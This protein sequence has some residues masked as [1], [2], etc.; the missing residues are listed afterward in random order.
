M[1]ELPR[2]V[3][4]G[5]RS[6]G[7][8]SVISESSNSPPALGV[9]QKLQIEQGAATTGEAG[10]YGVPVLLALVAVGE[11][12]VDVLEGEGLLAQLLEADD[13][14]VLGRVDPGLLLDDLGAGSLELGVVEDARGAGLL[15]A[16]LLDVDLVASVD[17]GL[18]GGGGQGRAVLEGL[19][20]RAEV[21]DGGRHGE[22]WLW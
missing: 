20:L 11:L 1:G 16:A 9:R 12:D 22:S 19:G 3:L 14:V 8:A 15:A 7:K 21:K 4:Q 13:D 6:T 2:P 10:E 5:Q 17:E 18:G